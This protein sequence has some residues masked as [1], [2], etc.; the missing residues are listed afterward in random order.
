MTDLET[1][2]LETSVAKRASSR[3]RRYGKR[4]VKFLVV[5]YVVLL[6]G[7]LFGQGWMIFPGK[8]T[9]GK[10]RVN[11][12]EAAAAEDTAELVYLKTAGGDRVVGLFGPATDAMERP[13]ADAA[14]R[15]TIL[16]FYGN[17]MAMAHA[18]GWADRFRAEGANVLICEYVGFGMSGG[19]ASEKNCY[20][21]A[22]ACYDYVMARPDVD[23]T[24]VIA[25]GVSLGGAVAIDLAARRPVAALMTFS[26]FTSMAEMGHATLPVVPTFMVRALL[27]HPFLS[28]SKIGKVHCPIFIAHGTIDE[29]VPHAMSD[30]LEKAAGGTVTRLE[31]PDT[32]HQNIF[33]VHPGLIWEAVGK[34]VGQVNSH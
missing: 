26:T 28:E 30:R 17:G 24:K 12:S 33:D 23:K 2:S 11:I 22:D 1:A 10:G 34:F 29:L 3:L 14:K 21:T 20:A 9:Q 7:I 18:V 25:V 27:L 19:H 15:P 32:G 5:L 31:I 4:L 8:T 13:L 16:L 6:L